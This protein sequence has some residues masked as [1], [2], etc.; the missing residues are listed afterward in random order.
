MQR[1]R[2]R[3]ALIG[4]FAVI[5]HG[6]VRATKDIDLLIDPSIENIQALKR[7]M[8]DLPD[9]AIALMEDN[10]VG[11]YSVVR[12]ADEIVVDLMKEA[13]GVDYEDAVAAGLEVFE[14]EGVEILLASK[15]T[16]IRTKDTVRPS[17]AAETCDGSDLGG[18]RARLEASRRS[19]VLAA[20][21]ATSAPLGLGP[22]AG[23]VRRVTV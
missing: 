13:C 12:I 7:A 22:A 4:G 5:I 14:L 15:Q 11:Q 20:P 17:D 16:L 21:T 2:V 18:L 8:A 9:N 1:E 19:F 10:E 23:W 3:Y 6:Y